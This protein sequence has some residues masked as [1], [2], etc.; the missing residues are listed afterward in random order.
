V[1]AAFARELANM[2]EEEGLKRA[3]A[4]RLFPSET[5]RSRESSGLIEQQAL[6]QRLAR[7]Q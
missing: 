5:V 1:D 7:R 2:T 4:L 3:Q 6:F